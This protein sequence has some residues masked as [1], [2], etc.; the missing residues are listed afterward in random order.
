[1]RKPK[2]DEYFALLGHNRG[3]NDFGPYNAK[4]KPIFIDA[5]NLA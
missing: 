5:V 4:S 2:C 1:M 3:L